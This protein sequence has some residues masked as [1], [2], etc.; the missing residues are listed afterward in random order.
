MSAPA[1]GGAGGASSASETVKVAVRCRPPNSKE[2]REGRKN[3]VDVN[4]S[5]GQIAI[6]NPAD[7]DV[8]TFTFDSVYDPASTQKAVYEE[9][10]FPLVEN[11]LAGYNGTIFAYGQTGSGKSWSMQGRND[12]VELRG[13]TPNSFE[14]IFEYIKA[15]E[16]K[17]EFLCRCSFLELYNEGELCIPPLHLGSTIAALCALAFLRAPPDVAAVFACIS[18]DTALFLRLFSSFLLC[19]AP[20]PLCRDPG[21]AGS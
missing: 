8:K 5:L 20:F 1:S 11:V 13:I 17:K 16:G 21:L 4:S 15:A 12:P 6:R 3:C 14:H 18:L 2:E 9:T 7:G 10:A 19:A